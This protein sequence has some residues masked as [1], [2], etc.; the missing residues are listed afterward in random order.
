MSLRLVPVAF[1]DAARFV[2]STH[3]QHRH[4]LILFVKIGTK[5]QKIMIPWTS[6]SYVIELEEQ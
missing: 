5:T 2:D 4:P 1:D 6:I 3:R